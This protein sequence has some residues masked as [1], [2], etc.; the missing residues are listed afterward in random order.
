M[1]K[2][3]VHSL[4]LP[5][6]ARRAAAAGQAMVE[7]VIILIAIMA[8]CMGMLYVSQLLTVQYWAQQDARLMAFEE[9][10]VP[11]L[12][13]DL[14]IAGST[15]DMTNNGRFH[16]T[17]SATGST[18]DRKREYN[19]D[20]PGMDDMFAMNSV[21]DSGA[22]IGGANGN[23]RAAAPVMMAALSERGP[24]SIWNRKSTDLVRT[25]NEFVDS[26]FGFVST[27]NA[28]LESDDDIMRRGASP[29]LIR[30]RQE[31]TIQS[32]GVEQ[33]TRAINNI[34]HKT[35]FGGKI[36]EVFA[37]SMR[38]H[39]FFPGPE[40]ESAECAASFEQGFADHLSR[41]ADI[42][43]IFREYGFEMKSGFNQREALQHS[44]ERAM[45]AGF[46][47]F[48]DT[49]VK[50]ARV[51]TVPFI[52]AKRLDVA[53]T[54]VSSKFLDM[55]TDMRFMG[56][57]V[58][59]G[60][61]ALAAGQAGFSDPS[62]H[63]V[64][65][66][67]DLEKDIS[68]MIFADA[69]DGYP[70]GVGN[71]FW[72]NVETI[73]P[74]PSL[75]TMIG[76]TFEGIAANVFFKEDDD[77]EDKIV[78][79]SNISVEVSYD[80]KNVIYKPAKR[81]FDTNNKLQVSR[82]YLITQEWHIDRRDDT[83]GGFPFRELGEQ[84]DDDSLTTDEAML[85]RRVSGLYLIPSN[86]TSFLGPIGG[87]FPPLQSVFD[88]LSPLEDI[89]GFVKDFIIDSP[90]NDIID[91]ISELPLIDLSGFKV[92]EWPAVRPQ[93]YPRSKEIEGDKLACPKGESCSRT[94][95]DYIQEQRDFNPDPNPSY[96]EDAE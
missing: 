59:L 79:Q 86:M 40:M 72:L 81:R 50:T 6:T 89:L 12:A 23:S 44:L 71:G 45:A 18:V 90:L 21:P 96:D 84:M 33:R 76:E 25:G 13:R 34:L 73:I 22:P 56:S 27:A 87:L 54:F 88:A 51:G 17:K 85:R 53:G 38:N 3:G 74:V 62:S 36:C 78:R 24:N 52:V 5:Q 48:F 69:S 67:V 65:D 61:I 15:L 39:G 1:I 19:P 41:T 70:I 95:D 64:Q 80:P 30:R 57:A 77:L 8:M 55:V 28:S 37:A 31:R 35:G 43:E 14:G 7:F 46:Y 83:G 92:P 60:T 26:A 75:G 49:A 82:F 42:A 29:E 20:E 10:W 66:S 63:N 2:S 4:T 32:A 91:F 94:F 58:A 16:R 9:T 93:A 11:R 68:D 47:S